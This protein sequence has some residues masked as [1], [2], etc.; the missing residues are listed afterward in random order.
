[1]PL[2][3]AANLSLL[4]KEVESLPGRYAAAK[5]A[6]F[7]AVECVF[8]YEAS[9]EDLTKAKEES[10]LDHV[11]MNAYP[12][13]CNP[14]I[15]VAGI[16]LVLTPSLIFFICNL[17]HHRRVISIDHVDQLKLWQF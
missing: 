6:G 7:K 5:N 11:L 8:P 1:M 3:F 9:V 14:V 10:G 4:F 2:K 13:K 17:R 16:I 12:G 15:K